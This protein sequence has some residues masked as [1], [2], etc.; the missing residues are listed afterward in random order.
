[1]RYFYVRKRHGKIDYAKQ[2][3]DYSI[4]LTIHKKDM[5]E[6]VGACILDPAELRKGKKVLFDEQK[7]YLTLFRNPDVNFFVS[8]YLSRLFVE[9]FRIK[10]KGQDDYSRWFNIHLLWEQLRDTIQF[11]EDAKRFRIL[12]EDG[13]IGKYKTARKTLQKLIRQNYRMTS[14]FYRE[15]NAGKNPS[16]F[17]KQSGLSD[18]FKKFSKKE[19]K[20]EMK[21]AEK[22]A[23]DFK[24]NLKSVKLSL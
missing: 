19:N 11:D 24:R 16:N 8:C 17:Y 1:M 7:H 15:A 21:K 6:A 18:E 10:K 2:G 3:L 5:A 20:Q 9:K 14:K 22:L 23:K 12:H 4:K 13:K